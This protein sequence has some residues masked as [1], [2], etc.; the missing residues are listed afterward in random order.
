MRRSQ[1]LRPKSLGYCTSSSPS[2]RKGMNYHSHPLTFLVM[3]GSKSIHWEFT[4]AIYLCRNHP[5][6]QAPRRIS[7]FSILPATTVLKSH[8]QNY[9]A[10]GTQATPDDQT[11]A[12]QQYFLSPRQARSNSRGPKRPR[13]RFAQVSPPHENR[14]R[15]TSSHPWQHQNCVTCAPLSPAAYPTIPIPSSTPQHPNSDQD[16]P[17]Q[18]PS[19]RRKSSLSPWHQYLHFLGAVD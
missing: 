15:S 4:R 13:S 11:P 6:S 18:D 8:P 14:A 5:A 9:A 10:S 1:M 3:F 17:T 19:R 12:A 7:R 2:Q 16:F